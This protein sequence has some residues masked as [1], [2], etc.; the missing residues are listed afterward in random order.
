MLCIL[1]KAFGFIITGQF[2]FSFCGLL[3]HCKLNNISTVLWVFLYPRTFLW[4]ICRCKKVPA[5]H[6]SCAMKLKK[7]HHEQTTN[8]A[9]RAARRYISLGW[10]TVPN[11]LQRGHPAALYKGNNSEIKHFKVSNELKGPCIDTQEKQQTL[12]DIRL[13][14]VASPQSE[15]PDL[16]LFTLLWIFFQQRTQTAFGA[17]R[18]DC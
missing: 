2:L 8:P 1:T 10:T 16:S 12:F 17:T 3:T 7:T 4:C 9:L 5:T 6:G 11:P 15:Q 18:P 13:S 14:G